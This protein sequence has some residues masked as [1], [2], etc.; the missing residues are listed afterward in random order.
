M[1][2]PGLL[3]VRGL[4]WEGGEVW[5]TGRALLETPDL[6]WGEL[7]NGLLEDRA[8]EEE[9]PLAVLGMPANV[10]WP[11]EAPGPVSEAGSGSLKGSINVAAA[12]YQV[13]T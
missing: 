5:P 4:P 10:L 9:D 3:R 1:R 13:S 7:R 8:C 11:N 6:C 2:P 12:W